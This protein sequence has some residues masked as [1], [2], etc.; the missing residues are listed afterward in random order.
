MN[1]II[2]AGVTSIVFCF[3]F[4]YSYSQD[5]EIVTQL[6]EDYSNPKPMMW[7]ESSKFIER[8]IKDGMYVA[9]ALSAIGPELAFPSK[10][11][12]LEC[13]YLYDAEFMIVKLKGGKKEFIGIKTSEFFKGENYF[14]KGAIDYDL[15]DLK[16][17]YFKYNELGE[18]QLCYD[19][20]KSTPV[21]SGTTTVLEKT[22]KLKVKHL[23]NKIEFYLNDN[24]VCEWAAG[25]SY[26]SKW[27]DINIFGQ[28][29][30]VKIA[31]D[32]VKFTGYFDK[33]NPA[34]IL[35][36][37]YGLHA[38]QI[39]Y[40]KAFAVKEFDGIKYRL[41]DNRG[42]IHPTTFDEF[43]SASAGPLICIKENGS[44]GYLDESGK[45]AVPIEYKTAAQDYCYETNKDCIKDS[46]RVVDKSGNVLFLNKNGKAETEATVKISSESPIIV[47]KNEP[48][49]S[50]DQQKAFFEAINKWDEAAIL[51]A[52]KKGA[53]INAYN[54]NGQSALHMVITGR[55]DETDKVRF[56]VENKANVNIR[57][58]KSMTT[59]LTSAIY[60]GNTETVKYLV[61]HAADVN[62]LSGFDQTP[63]LHAAIK[64]KSLDMVK[65]ILEAG[66]DINAISYWSKEK[67]SPL[68]IAE[69]MATV[70]I[71][72]YLKSKGA[73]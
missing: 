42:R 39:R 31:L 45:L 12:Q 21:Q 48:I 63:A 1:K 8:E 55:K 43:F 34:V 67:R 38:T 33:D 61:S 7:K 70:E 50:A 58:E 52:V 11:N 62:A 35:D 18:W 19:N 72:N 24:K 59:A 28:T 20:V 64:S 30:N 16:Y 57:H 3:S 14:E 49:K 68:K 54:E 27:S 69:E 44:Y 26:Q 5:P 29:D 13:V 71:S 56:L 25:K 4:I 40:K 73:K 65:I 66:A 23:K 10:I 15:R 53:Q 2:I 22:N 9:K 32:K 41:M 60:K 37:I 46:Y 6:E 17:L 51:A 47:Q 36:N